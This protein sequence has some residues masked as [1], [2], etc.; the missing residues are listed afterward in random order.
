VVDQ[1]ELDC[2]KVFK[3]GDEPKY[4]V[5]FNKKNFKKTYKPGE[6][7]GELA[8]LYNAPRAATIKAKVYK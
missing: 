6:S 3:K 4:L 2:Y 1:G 7:F 5:N 8:L